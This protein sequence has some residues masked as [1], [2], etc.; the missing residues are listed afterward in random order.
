MVFL[1]CVPLSSSWFERGLCVFGLILHSFQYNCF[2]Y[3][4]GV[5][6][7]IWINLGFSWNLCTIKKIRGCVQVCAVFRNFNHK[8]WGSLQSTLQIIYSEWLFFLSLHICSSWWFS[9]SSTS[10]WEAFLCI[11]SWIRHHQMMMMNS[12]WQQHS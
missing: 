4:N 5:V 2:R 1:F 10:Q 6:I 12:F 7:V 11:N 3:A 8:K 9:S